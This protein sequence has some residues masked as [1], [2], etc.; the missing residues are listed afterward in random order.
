[1]ENRDKSITSRHDSTLRWSHIQ[2]KIKIRFRWKRKRLLG[3]INTIE[4]RSMTNMK[5]FR[6]DKSIRRAP[7]TRIML[8]LHS[9]SPT[10]SQMLI[11]TLK[12]VKRKR[13]QGIKVLR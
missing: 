13:M 10:N 1:M 6:K 8:R 11:L 4:L 9:M 5:N 12:T 7:L 2:G 3:L